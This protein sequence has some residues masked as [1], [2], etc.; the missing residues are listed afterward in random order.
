MPWPYFSRNVS[1]TQKKIGQRL[2][3]CQEK[4]SSKIISNLFNNLFQALLKCFVMLSHL[5]LHICKHYVVYSYNNPL[6]GN[7]I[8]YSL[9]QIRKLRLRL[10][11]TFCYV[12]QLN[13]GKVRILLVSLE[14]E[15]KPPT[16]TSCYF[17]PVFV[18]DRK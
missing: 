15:F 6:K 13:G 17:P 7:I 3:S 18:E 2:Y 10:F 4:N 9:S 1:R 16:T 11:M 12:K 5:I 14:P 8:I